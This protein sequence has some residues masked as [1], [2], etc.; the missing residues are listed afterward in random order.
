MYIVTVK[1]VTLICAALSTL[2]IVIW[3]VS[4]PLD[5]QVEP[6]TGAWR[7]TNVKWK[8]PPAELQLKERY[9]EVAVIYFS[10]DQEF[11]LLYATV[12]QQ[13]KSEQISEGDGCVLYLGTWKP[14]DNPRDVEYRLVSRTI[15]TSGETLPGPVQTA[16]VQVRGSTVLFQ[17][18]RF[19]RDYIPRVRGRT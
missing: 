17:K 7:Q 13:P 9:A 8:K 18:D 19:E 6:P 15:A 10:S 14:T 3:F 11:A 1:R 12:I 16:H 4:A 5:A 2:V